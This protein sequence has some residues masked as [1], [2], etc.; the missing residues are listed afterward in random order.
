[1]DFFIFIGVMALAIPATILR[2]WVLSYLWIWFVVPIFGL[3]VISIVEAIAVSF[4]IGFLTH[5]S[6]GYD[7]SKD[8]QEKFVQILSVWFISP[9]LFLGIGWIIKGFM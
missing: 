7:W 2:G 4:I 1:M 3:P 8:T 9:F 6:T 5:G